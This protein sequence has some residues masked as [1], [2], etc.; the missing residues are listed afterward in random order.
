MILLQNSFRKEI[1]QNSN[2]Q[3]YHFSQLC[4]IQQGVI[5]SLYDSIKSL[6]KPYTN[7]PQKYQTPWFIFQFNMKLP[8]FLV[9]KH[10][11]VGLISV[12][13]FQLVQAG[14]LSANGLSNLR[15]LFI[16]PLRHEG[17]HLAN[18]SNKLKKTL[19]GSCTLENVCNQ[20]NSSSRHV[21]SLTLEKLTES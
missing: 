11:L 5:S 16:V 18:L 12:Q 4:Q 15:Y 1:S 20:L 2:S 6:V 13:K 21:F 17:Y 10:E 19:L 14:L 9:D 3:S 7:R 8:G